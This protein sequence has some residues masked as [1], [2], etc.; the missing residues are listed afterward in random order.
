MT[1]EQVLAHMDTAS[2]VKDME[3]VRKA[4][5]GD[6]T[7]WGTSY[8]TQYGYTYAQL[9]PNNIRAL[10][11]D[12]MLNHSY[13]LL[14][15]EVGTIASGALVLQHF[16]DWAHE[17][18]SSP[19]FGKDTAQIYDQVLEKVK[20]KPLPAPGCAK[21][22]CASKVTEWEFRGNLINFLKV[23][24]TWPSMA[25]GFADA[26]EGDA[27]AFATPLATSKNFAGMPHVTIACQDWN[28]GDGTWETQQNKQHA[29]EVLAPRGV[30]FADA[31]LT[32]IGCQRWPVPVTNPQM[33]STLPRSRH[34]YL[35]CTN[36]G[37]DTK[38]RIG[39]VDAAKIPGKHFVDQAGR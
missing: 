11:F 24:R 3:A 20:E 33:P 29:L 5:G 2:A 6:I 9:F 27:T 38:L 17:N 32:S 39:S 26:L 1:G 37:P 16:L 10:L 25:K 31:S 22:G 36:V 8:G 23:I 34:L 35:W 4:L 28:R 18:S 13:P 19:L 21:K 14:Q 12:A 30:G 7:Y 15:V